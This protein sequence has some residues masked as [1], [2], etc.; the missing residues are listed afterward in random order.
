MGVA[1]AHLPRFLSQNNSSL[2]EILRAEGPDHTCPH[3]G[4]MFFGSLPA[5]EFLCVWR[6]KKRRRWGMGELNLS[7]SWPPKKMRKKKREKGSRL[8]PEQSLLASQEPEAQVCCQLGWAWYINFISKMQF[9]PP[10]YQILELQASSSS[11]FSSQG[12]LSPLASTP[13]APP[14]SSWAAVTMPFIWCP[15][16]CPGNSLSVTVCVCVCVRLVL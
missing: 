12:S 9:A 10:L 3:A 11:Q 6:G 2:V 16:V 13:P 15:F 4:S 1:L 8:I 5:T 14:P 7:G